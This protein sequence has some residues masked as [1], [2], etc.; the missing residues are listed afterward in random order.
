MKS[1]YPRMSGIVEGY[2]YD[3]FISHYFYQVIDKDFDEPDYTDAQKVIA[4]ALMEAVKTT[5]MTPQ[6]IDQFYVRAFFVAC[7]KHERN[8]P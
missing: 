6:V 1:T 4:N 3:I 5:Y 7:F 2:N 8:G